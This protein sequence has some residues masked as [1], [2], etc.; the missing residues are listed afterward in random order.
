MN[1]AD[2]VGREGTEARPQREQCRACRLEV[3]TAGVS[4]DGEGLEDP[5]AREPIDHRAQ[6]QVAEARPESAPILHD[7]RLA[8]HALASEVSGAHSR[9]GR[10]GRREELRARRHEA[11]LEGEV[12]LGKRDRER[13]RRRLRGET[14]HLRRRGGRSHEVDEGPHLSVERSKERAR[15]NPS[16]DLVGGHDGGEKRP[17]VRTRVLRRSERGPHRGVARMSHPDDVVVVLSH[18]ERR[19]RERGVDRSAL[20]GTSDD[21]A[22]SARRKALQTTMDGQDLLG[23]CGGERRR[24]RAEHLITSSSPRR[25]RDLLPGELTDPAPEALEHGRRCVHRVRSQLACVAS[26]S[27]ASASRAPASR[28]SRPKRSRTVFEAGTL[29]GSGSVPNTRSTS[30]ATKP[31]Q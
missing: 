25:L 5:E 4:L 27:P 28:A 31:S 19:V 14:E 6:R 17:R 2:V 23:A 20:L 21:R 8:R 15:A 30:G 13:V 29:R 3:V 16:R 12:R 24:E 1:L 9:G 7:R 18:R 11:G 10:R 22:T 26:A